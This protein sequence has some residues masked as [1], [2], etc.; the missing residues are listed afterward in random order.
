LAAA[1]A[2]AAGAAA[3]PIA[4]FACAQFSFL[5][6]CRWFSQFFARWFVVCDVE[7]RYQFR[8]FE[9]DTF[10]RSI[11]AACNWQKVFL[12]STYLELAYN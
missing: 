3:A 5:T 1:A 6:Y 9:S 7:V 8:L 10:E 12:G 11:H 4:E 2:A